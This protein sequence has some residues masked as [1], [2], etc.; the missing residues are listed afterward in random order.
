LAISTKN[1]FEAELNCVSPKNA[2]VLI[3]LGGDGLLLRVLKDY[4]T[5]AVYGMHCGTVG[6]LM[7]RFQ[8]NLSEVLKSIQRAQVQIIHPL[9]MI[10]HNTEG[11]VFEG[12]AMN[13]VALFRATAQAAKIRIS[14]DGK[15][16]MEELCADG[17]LV[18][19]PAGSTA[20]NFSAHGPIIP[21]GGSLL[22]L[23]PISPFRPRR[24]RGALLPDSCKVELD[25]MYPDTRIVHAS[26]DNHEFRNVHKIAIF[27][28]KSV[29]FSLLFDPDHHLEERIICEQ[30]LG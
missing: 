25:V 23:T 4:P 11:D 2:D 17:L 3:V 29:S 26:C 27:L 20:Y 16:R 1:R 18:A 5:R 15:V 6:F 7:N 8:E 22:A 12:H 24:W 14:V 28:D 13:E 30:F 10:A 19:T 9:K 21:L